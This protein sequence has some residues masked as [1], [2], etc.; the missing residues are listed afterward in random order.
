MSGL[1]LTEY[2]KKFGKTYQRARLLVPRLIALGQAEKVQPGQRGGG[3]WVI[4]P[5]AGWAGGNAGRPKR[6]KQ[7]I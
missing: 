5:D 7:E 3:E 2:A 4:S 6:L 1:S